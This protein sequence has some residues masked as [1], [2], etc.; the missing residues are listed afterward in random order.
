MWLKLIR[1]LS[2]YSNL[3]QQ[4]R[5]DHGAPLRTPTAKDG[6]FNTHPVHNR[7]EREAFLKKNG[8]PINHL[9]NSHNVA[10]TDTHTSRSVYMTTPDPPLHHHRDSMFDRGESTL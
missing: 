1:M 4:G 10:T 9:F 8:R 6:G 7:A 3:L 5:L 2:I